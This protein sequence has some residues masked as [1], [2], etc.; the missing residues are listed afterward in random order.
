MPKRTEWLPEELLPIMPPSVARL[1]VEVSAPNIRPCALRGLVEVV[2]DDPRLHARRSRL[3]IDLEDRF[4]W[5]EKSST[6]ARPT[7]WPA[8][9]VPAPRA[10]SGTPRSRETLIAATTSA[11]VAGEHDRQRLDRIHA[12]VASEQMPRVGIA[13][14]LALA[15]GGQGRVQL[16]DIDLE[17]GGRR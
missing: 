15:S 12:R 5:R 6:S 7:V 8:R 14:H 17:V 13:A 9:L 1:L 4:M 10:S 11:C 16:R 3:G 2:L